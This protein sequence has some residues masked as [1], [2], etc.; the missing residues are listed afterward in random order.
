MRNRC[1]NCG[2]SPDHILHCSF[3]IS[4]LLA[5]IIAGGFIDI[6]RHIELAEKVRNL[7][8]RRGFRTNQE[9]LDAS[10]DN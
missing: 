4:L 3:T 8:L 2:G 1:A 7:E 5:N 9:V 10:E 6:S